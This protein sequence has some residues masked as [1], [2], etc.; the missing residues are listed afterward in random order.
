M[1]APDIHPPF[2]STDTRDSRYLFLDLKPP[3]SPGLTLT[4]AGREVCTP[5]YRIDRSGFEYHVLEFVVSGTWRLAAGGHADELRPGAL[6]AYGP[7]AS[8][9]LEACPGGEPIKYFMAFSGGAARSTIEKCGLGG[10][11]VRYA[12]QT[13]WIHDLFDQLIECGGLHPDVAREIG[14]RL[15]ELILLRVRSDAWTSGD[16]HSESLGSF[17]RCRRFIEENFITLQ[18]VDEVARRCSVDPTYLARLFK[19]FANERPLQFLTRL[20]VN[21]AADLIMRKGASVSQAAVEVGYPDPYHFSRVFKRVHGTSPGSL[22]P[23]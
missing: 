14:M 18:S 7:G 16:R 17:V 20:K 23:R 22:R 19:R 15:S 13:R 4:C 2:I 10:M 12:Q 21:H 3:R 1:G 11:Q 6:F 8:F 9:S 5:D